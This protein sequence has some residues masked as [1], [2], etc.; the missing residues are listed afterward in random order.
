MSRLAGRVCIVTGGAR[1]IGRAIAGAMAAEGAAVAIGD[2]AL[3]EAEALVERAE[4]ELGLPSILACSAGITTAGGAT[5]LL[6]LDDDEWR[7]VLDVDVGGVFLAAQAVTRRLVA[8]GRPGAIVTLTS[9]GAE[10]PMFGYP[11]YHTAKAAVTGLTRALAVNLAPHGIRANAI[12][13]GHVLTELT[14]PFLDGAAVDAL[15]DR[16]PQRRLGAPEDVAAAAVYLASDDAAYV[17]GEV[18][19]LDGGE[20]VLGW[21][22]ARALSGGQLERRQASETRSTQQLTVPTTEEA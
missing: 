7:R 16:I 17:T 20:H 2:V 19:H 13:P 12:A 1:G 18:L 8:A 11:A 6:E 22:A 3:D 9:I 4:Q 21:Q 5:T 14:R 10:R 15:L